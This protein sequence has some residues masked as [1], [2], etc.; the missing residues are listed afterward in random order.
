MPSNYQTC[1]PEM[2]S[3]T[4]RHPILDDGAD[5]SDP[6][7]PAEQQDRHMEKM[8]MINHDDT[9][10]AT[11]PFRFRL[12]SE[13][14]TNV[15]SISETKDDANNGGCSSGPTKKYQPRSTCRVTFTVKKNDIHFHKYTTADLSNASSLLVA[16]IA[17]SNYNFSLNVLKNGGG[18]G[19]GG[20]GGFATETNASS[21]AGAGGL[22]PGKINTYIIH[23]TYIHNLLQPFV[24]ILI[25]N[26]LSSSSSYYY[27]GTFNSATAFS[28]LNFILFL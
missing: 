3:D 1:I 23:N 5:L 10:Y 9:D 15:N 24:K 28:F 16:P 4:Q 12:G 11:I 2:L 17:P 25:L 21:G 18:G 27:Y 20:D 13:G 22:K 8:A 26:F 19:G 7:S 6:R 14:F